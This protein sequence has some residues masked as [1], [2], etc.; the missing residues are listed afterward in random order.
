MEAH[1]LGGEVR[2]FGRNLHDVTG[3]PPEVVEVVQAIPG[4]DLVLDGEAMGLMDGG[5]PRAFQ[6][7]M[8]TATALDTFFFDVLLAEAAPLHDEPLAVRRKVLKATVP[9]SSRLLSIVTADVVEAERF[10][11]RALASGH[12]GVM[13]MYLT[14]PYEAGRR[15]KGWRKVEPVYTFDLVVLAVE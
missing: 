3:R 15:S 5:S 8:R 9:E 13:V 10:L 12:E 7:S 1:R 2:L 4:R 6:D 14:Q 11:K